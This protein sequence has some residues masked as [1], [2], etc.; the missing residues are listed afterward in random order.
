M[1]TVKDHSF[2][3]HDG[4]GDQGFPENETWGVTPAEAQL[5]GQP[6]PAPDADDQGRQQPPPDGST[7]RGK[8]VNPTS[9]NRTALWLLASFAALFAM[10]SFALELVQFTRNNDG[11]GFTNVYRP[12]LFLWEYLSL[13][14]EAAL[15]FLVGTVLS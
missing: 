5:N 7:D 9:R 2:G 13:P 1:W 8:E 11:T 6:V 4:A 12:S 14:W 15:H 3:S 10:V